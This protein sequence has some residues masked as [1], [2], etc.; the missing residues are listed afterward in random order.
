M[1]L[2]EKGYTYIELIV[3]ITIASLVVAATSMVIFQVLKNSESN[4]NHMTAVNQ[5]QNA[6]Y[7]ISRDTQMA[8]I[9]TTDALPL[10]D[11]LV[12]RWT[13][14]DSGDECQIVYTLED[15]PESGLKILMR[16]QSINGSANTTT[17]VA[18]YINSNSENT[19]CQFIS[20]TLNLT[21]TATVGDGSHME[22]ESRTYQLVPRSS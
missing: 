18:R 16:N 20:G 7:W 6:G 1:K 3:A 21:I 15:M 22:S 13:D 5:V 17:L 10:P 9:V 2:G 8:Q 14:G 11:F 19:T 4:S 12:L